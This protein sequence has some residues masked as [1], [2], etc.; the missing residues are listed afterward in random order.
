MEA[1]VQ[2]FRGIVHFKDGSK[3][4]SDWFLSQAYVDMFGEK[5]KDEENF[6]HISMED[7]KFKEE[8]NVQDRGA[9]VHPFNHPDGKYFR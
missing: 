1:M 4:E 2:K 3:I 5:Y 8:I 9:D 7:A 6:S